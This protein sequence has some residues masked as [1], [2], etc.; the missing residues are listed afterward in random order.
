MKNDKSIYKNPP[1]E[2]VCIMYRLND[3][4]D[5]SNWEES[6]EW[7][8]F[9]AGQKYQLIKDIGHLKNLSGIF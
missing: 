9:L 8:I 1:H 3:Q 5:F 2:F 4:Y 7:R 6:N